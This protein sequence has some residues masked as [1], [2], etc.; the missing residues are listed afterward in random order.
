MNS[1]DEDIPIHK[2]TLNMTK[3][4]I[5]E[6]LSILEN[7]NMPEIQ[8]KRKESLLSLLKELYALSERPYMNDPLYF[9]S[10][11]QKAILSK[12]LLEELFNEALITKNDYEDIKKKLNYIL[13]E[14]FSRQIL[15]D[16][17]GIMSAK[18]HKSELYLNLDKWTL[19]KV[20]EPREYI[21]IIP[22][23]LSDLDAP[24][25]V[26][27]TTPPHYEQ[28]WHDHWENRE[29]TFYTWPSIGKFKNEGKEECIQADFWDF[30]IFPPKTWHTIENPTDLPVKNLSVKLPSSLLDRGKIY[31]GGWWM[32]FTKKLESVSPNH[33][34]AKF[35]E[36]WVPYHIEVYTFDERIDK[37]SISTMGRSLIYC[38]NGDFIV[39]WLGDTKQAVKEGDAI[40][41]DIHK[42][43]EVVSLSKWGSLYR[44]ELIVDWDK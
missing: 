17:N 37:H 33:Y 41:L 44:V 40:F 39:E 13:F 4:Y 19:K 38:I 27:A 12:F 23:A 6:L 29:I 14:N 30:I 10:R 16:K 31:N 1:L 20:L 15:P 21:G 36:Q 34:F 8:I 43:I 24:S 3:G 28:P 32:K 11:R 42:N 26:T 35:E 7:I 25:L 5:K 9:F 18:N 2:K 22:E